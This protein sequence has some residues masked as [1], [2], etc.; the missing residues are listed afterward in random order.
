MIVH[1]YN[2]SLPRTWFYPLLSSLMLEI[3]DDMLYMADTMSDHCVGYL[4]PH[5]P[6]TPSRWPFHSLT[7]Q[8]LWLPVWIRARLLAIYAY[9]SSNDHRLAVQGVHFLRTAPF[10]LALLVVCCFHS[11]NPCLYLSSS[12]SPFALFPGPRGHLSMS[13]VHLLSQ[14]PGALLTRSRR[15]QELTP[16]LLL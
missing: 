7:C 9:G 1:I 12:T 3:Q 16:A 2:C 13:L 10:P 8:L 5:T 4:L 11:S 14:S 6:H 15:F